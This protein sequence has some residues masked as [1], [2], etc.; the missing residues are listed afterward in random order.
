MP[1][2]KIVKVAA[3]NAGLAI[4]NTVL[5]SPGLIGLQIGGVSALGTAFGVTAIFMSVLLFGYGLSL[6]HI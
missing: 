3:L 1:K 2:D 5:F 6:I 4:G